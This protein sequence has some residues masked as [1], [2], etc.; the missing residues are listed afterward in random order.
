MLPEAQPPADRGRL[1]A[2]VLTVAGAAVI[3]VLLAGSAA[4]RLRTQALSLRNEAAMKALGFSLDDFFLD[5]GRYPR[6]DEGLAALVTGDPDGDGSSIEGWRGPYLRLDG[7]RVRYDRLS[8]SFLDA[9]GRSV[10]YWTDRGQ[11]WVYAASP[12]ADGRFDTP[13]IGGPDFS[14]LPDGSDDVI[15]WAEGP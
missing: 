11:L 14:G 13:G 2:A 6:L 5:V 12:G 15:V 3:G 9:W 1:L 8:G 10:L 7:A 4:V